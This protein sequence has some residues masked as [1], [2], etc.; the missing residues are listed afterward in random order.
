MQISS[1]QHSVLIKPSNNTSHLPTADKKVADV[2]MR[3]DVLAQP[4]TREKQATVPQSK[5]RLD[6]DE[7]AITSFKQKEQSDKINFNQTLMDATSNQNQTAVSTYQ[8]ISNLTQR[9]SIQQLFGVD[10]FV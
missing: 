9:E 2:A 10:V 7:K 6:F 3:V 1:A 8:V 4:N 5:Q